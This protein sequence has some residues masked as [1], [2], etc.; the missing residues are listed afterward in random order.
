MGWKIIELENGEKLSLFL[1]N[2][3]IRT[4]L[5]KITIPLSDIDTII[6]HNSKLTITSR[7]L[8]ALAKHNINFIICDE[9]HDPAL[10]LI[11]INGH[12]NSLKIFSEQLNWTEKYKDFLWTKIINQKIVNQAN[13]ILKISDNKEIYDSLIELSNDIKSFDITNREGHASKIYW[14]ALF[15]VEFNRRDD[16][17]ENLV[18]NYGYSILRSMITRSIIK[19]GLDPRISLFHKSFNN[20]FALASDF[21]E[22]FRFCVDLN[23]LEII[24]ETQNI[25]EAKTKMLERLSNYKLILNKKGYFVNN[26]IDLFIDF[27]INQNEFPNFE[28]I[29]QQNINQWEL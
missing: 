16:S 13:I 4:E 22:P 14:H 17:F 24:K 29:W 21:I 18:L 9:K 8:V 19:K 11:N 2:L 20:F 12:F 3:I 1:D 25:Y 28:I 6:T 7:L 27:I 15:S 26:A 23:M 10:Q 5:S